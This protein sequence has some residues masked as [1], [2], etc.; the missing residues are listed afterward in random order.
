MLHCAATVK[1]KSPPPGK[2]A[3]TV[4]V[5]ALW[6]AGPVYFNGRALVGIEAN[7]HW[8]SE[9]LSRLTGV[10]SISARRVFN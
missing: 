8:V 1:K 7:A 9:V 10:E 5:P 4:S 6:E 2:M 3:H